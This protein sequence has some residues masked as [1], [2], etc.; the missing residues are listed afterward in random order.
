MLFLDVN[1]ARIKK[2]VDYYLSHKVYDDIFL[3]GTELIPVVLRF[4]VTHL[5]N[6]ESATE[7]KALEQQ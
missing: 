5:R 7:F 4:Q 6:V 1:V 2:K 3:K